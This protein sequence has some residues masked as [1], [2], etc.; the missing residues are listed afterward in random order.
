MP[1]YVRPDAKEGIY[2]YDFRL[3][4][5]RFSG[6]TGTSVRREAERVEKTKREEAQAALRAA[7]SDLADGMT[8]RLAI[9]RFWEQV[10]KHHVNSET[11]LWSL[12]W[13]ERH[14]GPNRLLSTIGDP[15]IAAMVAKRRGENVPLRRKLKKGEKPP[16]PKRVGPATVNRSVTQ[17]MRQIML[18]AERVWNQ[19]VKHIRWREHLLPEPD[20]RIREAR[21]DE[22][23]ATMARLDRGYDDAVEFAFRSGCRRMEIIGLSWPNVD[24]FNRRFKVI[25]KGG[26][27]RFV[28][29][30]DMTFDLIWRQQGHHPDQVFTFEAE[31]TRKMPDGRLLERGKRYPLTDAGLRTAMRRAVSRAGVV[32]FRF[33][34]T[35]H[36]AATRVLRKSNLRVVQK[37]LGHRNIATTT[38]YAHALEEDI[39]T[40]LEA[41]DSVPLP[42]P[43]PATR[44][45]A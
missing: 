24:F 25:G 37:L 1:V 6:S 9:G 28:P 8:I 31:R 38:K 15:E 40:A 18:R 4:G 21:P 29:M 26:R 27:A 3:G 12:D 14:F 43:V 13:L 41:V 30:T 19:R 5:H 34:D 39:R 11:T 17:P 22:E 7:A 35:R 2:S 23:A 36:T 20:E 45:K 42:R 10:G 16:E 33:H 32:D 44:N